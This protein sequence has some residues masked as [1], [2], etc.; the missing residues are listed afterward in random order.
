MVRVSFFI[1]RLDSENWKSRLSD[2]LGEAKHVEHDLEPPIG[3]NVHVWSTPHS[4]CVG[5]KSPNFLPKVTLGVGTD[6]G[7]LL[8][9]NTLSHKPCVSEVPR[10]LLIVRLPLKYNFFGEPEKLFQKTKILT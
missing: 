4:M 9:H 7:W 6:Y 2:L 3:T 8:V 1:Y 5:E 10:L